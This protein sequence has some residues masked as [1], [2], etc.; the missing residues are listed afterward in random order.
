MDNGK[1]FTQEEAQAIFDSKLWEQW[2]FEEKVRVQLFQDRLVMP[3]NKFHEAINNVLDR[4]VY[5][6][7]FSGHGGQAR[8]IQEYL[9]TRKAP[10]LE[11]IIE[12][13]PVEKHIILQA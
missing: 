8:L 12:L 2:T 6:H 10:T 7:E 13:I 3:F 9:G 11:E 5:S 1:Q 4:A